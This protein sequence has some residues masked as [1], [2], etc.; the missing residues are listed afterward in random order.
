MIEVRLE[1][2]TSTTENLKL[3]TSRRYLP[4]E[5]EDRDERFDFR[6]KEAPPSL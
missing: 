3:V 4:G 2:P 1:T 6:K 5:L